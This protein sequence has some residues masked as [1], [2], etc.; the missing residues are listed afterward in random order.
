MFR[1]AYGWLTGAC[2]H[3]EGEI[4]NVWCGLISGRNGSR[5]NKHIYCRC[6]RMQQ[7]TKLSP[8]L[9]S[10]ANSKPFASARDLHLFFATR[11]ALSEADEIRAPDSCDVCFACQLLCAAAFRLQLPSRKGTCLTAIAT[12]DRYF[13]AYLSCVARVNAPSPLATEARTKIHCNL[14]LLRP[15]SAI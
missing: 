3:R 15:E 9:A 1:K 6:Y 5:A 4:T 2:A 12:C 11:L 8:N 13:R 14:Q 7:E 10:A